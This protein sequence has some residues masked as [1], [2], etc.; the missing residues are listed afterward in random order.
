MNIRRQ[1]S[2]LY[3]R[4]IGEIVRYDD[5]SVGKETKVE[6]MDVDGEDTKEEEPASSVLLLRFCGAS[7]VNQ[8]TWHEER[9]CQ[10]LMVKTQCEFFRC[11]YARVAHTPASYSCL[12]A[13]LP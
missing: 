3:E 7:L 10:C 2:E 8:K 11:V 5:L 12:G 6:K 13:L 1:L 9:R 4:H